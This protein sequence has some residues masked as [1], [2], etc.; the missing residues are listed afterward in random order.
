[1]KGLS[2]T[3]G[4]KELFPAAAELEKAIKQGETDSMDDSLINNFE[5]NL[6]VVLD[7]IAGLEEQEVVKKRKKDSA[8]DRD[9]TR[10]STS[11]LGHLEDASV[12]PCVPKRCG[13]RWR[14]KDVGEVSA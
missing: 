6:R 13:K 1:V 4:A 7:G 14:A 12:V 10:S 2:G 11:L 9:A 5:A 3:L 8:I